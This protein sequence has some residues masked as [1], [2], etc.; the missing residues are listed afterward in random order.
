MALGAFAGFFAGML[1]IGGGLVM[2]PILAMFFAADPSFPQQE[3]LH[4][5]LGTSMACII[6]TSISSLKTHH[7]HGAVMWPVVKILTPAI[8][9]GTAI[10]TV[11]AAQ[12]PTRPLA[13]FF[14]GFVCLVAAQMGFNLKPKPNRQLPGI[15]GMT[16]TGLLIGT[17]SSLVA[18]GG[19]SLTVPFLSWCNTKI[20]HA[21][22]TSAA[23]GLPIA[24][25]GTAGY[26]TNGWNTPDL[27]TGGTSI[28]PSSFRE[29][30]WF[31]SLSLAIC[32]RFGGK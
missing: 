17:L 16:L 21:I 27:P 5:A 11:I 32:T 2:V 29:A 4:L 22:G 31:S 9:L 20:Q 3:I 14:T 1:G 6:F 26:I 30:S 19:G 10:G 23:V 18:I 28:S 8:L 15:V 12:I 13:V 24:I 25:G 7:K